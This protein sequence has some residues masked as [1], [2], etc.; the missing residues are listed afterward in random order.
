MKQLIKLLS[1]FITFLLILFL[2]QEISDLSLSKKINSEKVSSFFTTISSMLTALTVFLLYKQIGVQIEDRK[3]ST[4]PDCK[5]P[6]FN[7][8]LEVK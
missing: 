1:F 3:V 4:K 8:S 5:C 2:W 6:Y 7:D